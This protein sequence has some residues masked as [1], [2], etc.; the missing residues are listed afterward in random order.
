MESHP[1]SNGE[2]ATE[3]KDLVY[4]VSGPRVIFENI[5][6]E[7]ILVHMERG[8]YF[9]TDEV[10]AFIWSMIEGRATRAEIAHALGARYEERPE[11]IMAALGRFLGRLLEEDLVASEHANGEPRT[12]A[13]PA[14]G[15]RRAFTVPALQTYRDMQDML[16]L[17]PIHDVEAAGWPVPKLD[18]DSSVAPAI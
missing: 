5:D 13:P 4:R 18:D 2:V 10:G 8:A 16:S 14:S 17:D 15:E 12:P 1:Q 3:P 7:L 6:G 9:S 11:A